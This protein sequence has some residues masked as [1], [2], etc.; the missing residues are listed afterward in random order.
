MTRLSSAPSLIIGLSHPDEELRDD[1]VALVA[2]QVQCVASVS[3]AAGLVDLLPGSVG[4][5]QDDGAEVLLGRRP[6][7]LL[8]QRQVGAGQRRQEEALLVLRP[9]PALT[10]LPERQ[11]TET[12]SQERNGAILSSFSH[13]HERCSFKIK[14]PD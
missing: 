8:A 12:E 9:D 5:Q 14:L 1:H 4:E 3:L 2:G 10:L 13:A 6:Q 11:D 7:Q